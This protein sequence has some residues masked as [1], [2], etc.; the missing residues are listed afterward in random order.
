MQIS[1]SATAKVYVHDDTVK[2]V[3]HGN[4]R[5]AYLNYLYC[6]HHCSGERL[7]LPT[8]LTLHEDRLEITMP[9]GQSL[10]EYAVIDFDFFVRQALESICELESKGILH[11]DIKLQNFVFHE[12]RFKLIDFD[13][14]VNKSDTTTPTQSHYDVAGYALRQ[15]IQVT[16]YNNLHEAFYAFCY[17]CF[18]LLHPS[19]LTE[20]KEID[21]QE[22][23]DGLSIKV[24]V[25]TVAAQ[26]HTDYAAW[27]QTS[28]PQ[29]YQEF[30][31]GFFGTDGYE[32]FAEARSLLLNQKEK[33]CL[34]KW[35]RVL[36]VHG[37]E[38]GL[39]MR[40]MCIALDNF[41]KYLDMTTEADIT[42]YITSCFYHVTCDFSSPYTQAMLAA[43]KGSFLETEVHEQTRM[44]F[45]YEY[46]LPGTWRTKMIDV[47]G[48]LLAISH[49]T[50]PYVY[51]G[52]K[53]IKTKA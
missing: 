13:L 8:N 45:I 20:P 23:E 39:S 32:S 35:S 1:S 51:L 33:H 14:L 28:F 43:D 17:T 6:L 3:V 30:F 46:A 22:A 42:S 19:F 2:K 37:C 41:Y 36:Y 44:Y 26:I 16:K 7:L 49:N 40:D 18:R 5:R 24:V 29:Q 15:G 25:N 9:K 31:G 48:I 27:I 21:Y 12:G 34:D 11:A 38:L 10:R 53:P 50:A 47:G 52:D 4:F